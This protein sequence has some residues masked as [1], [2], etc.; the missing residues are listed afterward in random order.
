[1]KSFFL[2]FV[3]TTFFLTSFVD[4][5]AGAF[6]GKI[7]R[8]HTADIGVFLYTS[9]TFTTACTVKNHYRI[10]LDKPATKYQVANAI[11]AISLDKTVRIV[12]VDECDA[13]GRPL[14]FDIQLIK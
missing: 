8:V 4:A 5:F 3:I 12:D 11:T 13:Q 10:L 1:M 9:S 6:Q 2:V 7:T 14:V